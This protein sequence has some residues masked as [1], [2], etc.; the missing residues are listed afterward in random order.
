MILTSDIKPY[1]SRKNQ[2]INLKYYNANEK[3]Y[4]CRYDACG[5]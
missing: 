5:S 2:S 1:I 4:G 3:T